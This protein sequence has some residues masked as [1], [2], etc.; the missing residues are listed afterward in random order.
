MRAAPQLPAAVRA[1]LPTFITIGAPKAGTTSLHEYLAEHPQIAMS[2]PKEPMCFQPPDWVERMR[3]YQRLFGRDA[4]VRGESSTAYT[5]YPW[6]PEVP[7]RVHATIPDAKLI[8][9]VRDPIPR[10]LSHYAQNVWDGFDVRPFDELMDDLEHPMNMPVWSSRYATQLERWLAHF[11]QDRILVLDAT[12]LRSQRAETLRRV[13]TFLG[14]DARFQ[15][16]RWEREH[17]TASSHVVPT[18]AGRR[19]GR[20]AD[21]MARRP[22]LRGLVAREVRAPTLR[23]QQRERL[24]HLLRPEADRLRSMTGLR[25]SHWE[26]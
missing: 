15:S 24:V 17:N 5:A 20:F 25:L 11:D 6:A 12:E 1:A 4:D 10:L 8:Y 21:A 22:R 9:I 19:L 3:E 26:I 13:F 18:A 2:E 7:A 23:P 14:V 16:P